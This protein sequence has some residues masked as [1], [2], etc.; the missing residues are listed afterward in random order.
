[1][2]VVFMAEL[3][4]ARAFIRRRSL[5]SSGTIACRAGMA[6]DQTTPRR[7]PRT[8]MCQIWMRSVCTRM[9]VISELSAITACV[10]CRRLRFSTRSARVPPTR[11][12][13]NSGIP[14]AMLTTPSAVAE[15]VMSKAR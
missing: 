5:T 14:Q 7:N 8:T 6:K 4:S 12:R 9:A 11:E 2:R 15:P 3:F 1:M 13:S 10:A